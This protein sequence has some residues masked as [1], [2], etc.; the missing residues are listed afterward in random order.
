MGTIWESNMAMQ[1]TL[2]LGDVRKPK[3]NLD[4]QLPGLITGG[5]VNQE[6]AINGEEN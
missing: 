1:S 2:F 6:M 4:F 5:Y 3:S